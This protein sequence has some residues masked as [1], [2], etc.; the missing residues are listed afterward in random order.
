MPP[1]CVPAA[2]FFSAVGRP[3]LLLSFSTGLDRTYV[4][5]CPASNRRMAARME[6]TIGPVTATSAVMA[7]SGWHCVKR[8]PQYVRSAGRVQFRQASIEFERTTSEAQ[9]PPCGPML[10]KSANAPIQPEVAGCRQHESNLTK[11]HISGMF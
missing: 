4:H 2:V 9:V 11:M 3:V 10:S 8:F 5:S 1:F 7:P 6:R